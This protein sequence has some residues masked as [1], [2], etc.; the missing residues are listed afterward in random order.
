M[1]VSQ[2]ILD[3]NNEELHCTDSRDHRASGY[4]LFVSFLFTAYLG[5]AWS[6]FTTKGS[7]FIVRFLAYTIAPLVL[8]GAVVVRVRFVHPAIFDLSERTN[9][10]LIQAFQDEF[11][12]GILAC[13]DMYSVYLNYLHLPSPACAAPWGTHLY[14]HDDNFLQLQFVFSLQTVTRVSALDTLVP[15]LSTLF[16]I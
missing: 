1:E 14:H 10:Y 11:L 7:P 8:L 3:P 2:V 12:L 5:G 15:C 9:D 16:I 6:N 4:L 13:R